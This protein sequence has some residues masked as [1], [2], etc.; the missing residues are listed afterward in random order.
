[1]LDIQMHLLDERLVRDQGRLY[2]VI[3]CC[4]WK[5][6][7]VDGPSNIGIGADDYRKEPAFAAA[8]AKRPLSS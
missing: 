3:A 7:R 4:S 6:A 8:L 2:Q 5:G 1:M